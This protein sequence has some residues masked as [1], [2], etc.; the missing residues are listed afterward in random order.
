M[1]FEMKTKCP[2]I[3]KSMKQSVDSVCRAKEHMSMG[4]CLEGRMG[5]C[6]REGESIFCKR[7]KIM[8]E[9]EP[10]RGKEF[11]KRFKVRGSFVGT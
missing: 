4:A 6:K 9:K 10:D 8:N 5:A 2:T 7:L 11:C 1:S 3:N